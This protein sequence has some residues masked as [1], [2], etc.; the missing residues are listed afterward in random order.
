MLRCSRINPYLQAK[1]NVYERDH[2][3]LV[4]I[5]EWI[6]IFHEITLWNFFK[7]YVW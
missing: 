5:Q 1:A 7:G 4:K 3:T 6:E 2:K